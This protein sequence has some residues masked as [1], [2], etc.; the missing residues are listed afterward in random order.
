MPGVREILAGVPWNQNGGPH[1]G[2]ASNQDQVAYGHLSLEMA[3]RLLRD[4]AL[5]ATG[6]VPPAPA[7]QLCPHALDEDCECRKPKPGMLIRV[8]KHYGLTPD[9]AVFVGNHEV[10]CEAAARA[11]VSFVWAADFFG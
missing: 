3:Q 1:L 4:L 6:T 2:L 5:A 8:M 10:D 9:R 7:L 11:G